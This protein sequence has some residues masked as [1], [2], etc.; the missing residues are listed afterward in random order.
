MAQ[1]TSLDADGSGRLDA[2]EIKKALKTLQDEAE[3]DKSSLR[4]LTV[5]A[6]ETL[7]EA[8][9][10]QAVWTQQREEEDEEAAEVARQEALAEEAKVA[11]AKAAKE[12]KAAALAD[13]KAADAKMK[14]EF[15]A[16]VRL[17]RSNTGVLPTSG[18]PSKQ[19]Q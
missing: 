19:P 13:K 10:A 17:K 1:F 15:E 8:R 2:G 18:D 7:K 3:A 6:A 5:S 4:K 9:H 12:A 16:K 14:E 11:D